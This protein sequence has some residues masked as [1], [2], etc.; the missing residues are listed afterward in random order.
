MTALRIAALLLG[1]AGT[2]WTMASVVGALVVPRATTSRLSA[3]LA[4]LTRGAFAAMARRQRDY[5]DRDRT[6]AYL[7]PVFLLLRLAVWSSLLIL[8]YA[9]ILWPLI[10][11]SFPAALRLSG[12]SMFTLGFAATRGGPATAVVFAEAATGLVMVALQISY[13]PT[14][15]AAYNRRERLVTMLESSGGAPA[16][17]P[18]ILAR[19]ALIGSLDSL[20]A[21]YSRWEEW[22]ADV[23]ESHSSYSTLLYFRSPDPLRSWVLGLL[24][25]M[26]A[27]ALHLALCPLSAPA[28]ARPLL[29]MG[30]VC[31]RAVAEVAEIPF[32]PD[33]HP[34]DPLQLTEREFADAVIRM[35]RAGWVVERTPGGAW[36][37]FRG[38]RVNYEGIAWAL[39]D[40]VA[41]PPGPWSGPRSAVLGASFVPLRPPDRQPPTAETQT[42]RELTAQRRTARGQPPPPA[43]PRTHGPRAR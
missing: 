42:V 12:S 15:Y 38:W 13:L 22:A 30:T 25:V 23:A 6:L 9:L 4:G 19:H 11:G 20:P 27:A 36:P 41:A 33:P 28:Q 26:D 18:E 5:V 40:L 37:H 24:A 32:D 29:R 7:A 8:S 17:G 21:L 16:W 1:V 31:L 43:P 2:V 10:R 14:L 3:W 35:E 34:E 39:A